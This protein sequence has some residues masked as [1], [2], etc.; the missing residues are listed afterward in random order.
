MAQKTVLS[1]GVRVV[2]ER[3]P[4]V[5]SVS[6]G[7]WIKAGTRHELPQECGMAHFLEH[8]LFKG[9]RRYSAA[10][11]SRI[12]D[13]VGGFLNAFTTKEYTCF[14]VKVLKDHMRLAVDLLA[15]IFFNS[16]FAPEEIDKE[17]NV[18]VQEINMV[19]DTPDDY[20]QDLFNQAFFH[21]HPLGCNILGD[22]E[23]VSR[24]GQED[25]TGFF[26]REYLVPGRIII[27]AAGSIGHPEFVDAV[28]GYF[29]L[30]RGS[31][32]KDTAH[33]FVP[34]RAVSF[35][36]RPLEQVHVSIGTHGLDQH[37]R[38]RHALF[39]LNVISGGSMSSRL[40]Q[41]IRENRGLAY[42]V[43]S[44]TASFHDA[45]MYGVYMGVVRETM[46]E[47]LEVVLQQLARF[48]RE[49][50]TDEELVHAKEQ[51]KGNLLLA[52]ECTDSRM[53]R[54]A[55]CE[56]YHNAYIP[57]QKV[58]REIEAVTAETVCELA[59]QMFRD[60]F[61][62]FTFLGPLEAQDLAPEC[63]LLNDRPTTGV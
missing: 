50:V 14:Y 37:D 48:S 22:L 7:I 35:N 6:I 31:R 55:K 45:G 27:S 19:K 44:F 41:E 23:T 43:Y 59:R 53:S 30:L 15:D 47:A 39:V 60:D 40:F 21:G 34:T 29:E 1:N 61:L 32:A 13:S 38:N 36:V 12:I 8:M 42:S 20:I 5:H 25:I 9:T 63:L 51:L 10:D 26:R 49:P 17:R 54:L 3:V 46:Q 4:G 16:V 58:L 24:F 56:I 2:T 11:I 18:V 57:I 62:T 28:G 52:L 33:P